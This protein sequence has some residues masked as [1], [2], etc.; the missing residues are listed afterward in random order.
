MEKWRTSESL[1][2]FAQAAL[3]GLDKCSLLCLGFTSTA[4][5][6][7]YVA[8]PRTELPDPHKSQ[9]PP[10]SL[11]L[12][13]SYLSFKTQGGKCYLLSEAFPDNSIWSHQEQT[14]HS[15]FSIPMAS[16]YDTGHMVLS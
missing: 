11:L 8:K 13:N 12:E 4:L 9:M 14:G 2:T 3:P 6:P 5:S 10:G 16:R 7:H 15:L 1:C